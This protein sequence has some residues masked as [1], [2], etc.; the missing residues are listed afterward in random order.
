MTIP[1]RPPGVEDI[2]IDIKIR[3]RYYND[4]VTTVEIADYESIGMLVK[5]IEAA[6]E[7]VLTEMP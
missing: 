1:K 6:L 5:R 4:H 7:R 2:V 3:D